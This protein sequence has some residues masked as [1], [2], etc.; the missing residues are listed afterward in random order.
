MC[1][2]L[3]HVLC[4]FVFFFFSSRRRHT[5]S[6]CD[7]SSDV[8]SSDLGVCPAEDATLLSQALRD[9]LPDR[10]RLSEAAKAL[11]FSWQTDDDPRMLA[12]ARA[13]IGGL[14]A[15]PVTAEMRADIAIIML[16]AQ[17]LVAFF[18]QLAARGDFHAGVLVRALGQAP[19]QTGRF[20]AAQL[21]TIG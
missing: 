1:I 11:Q 14:E 5:R 21:G 7:W 6:L 9:V 15:D 16:P 4:M 18:L 10:L 20:T 19:H 13:A 8:C 3:R 2:L 17:D 12:L